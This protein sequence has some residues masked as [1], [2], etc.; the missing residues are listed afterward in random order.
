[1]S[2][3]KTHLSR[4][5]AERIAARFVGYYPLAAIVSFQPRIA[6]NAR[7]RI[8]RHAS[9]RAHPSD[10][11]SNLIS[12]RLELSLRH[13]WS[14]LNL[15]RAS[16]SLCSSWLY[17]DE[18]LPIFDDE[19]DAS[20]LCRLLKRRL[21]HH[22]RVRAHVEPPHQSLS[23][24]VSHRQRQL[25]STSLAFNAR[26]VVQSLV[27]GLDIG[28]HIVDA[29]ARLVVGVLGQLLGSAPGLLRKA[30]LS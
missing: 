12:M 18:D 8:S 10:P 23:L 15:P 24:F 28:V 22:H 17:V 11:W 30:R 5:D 29:Y 6:L 1:M 7:M 14:Q 13:Q 19:L 26:P 2:T 20:S 3:N 4:N 27:H 16:S 21:Q 9:I 25:Q